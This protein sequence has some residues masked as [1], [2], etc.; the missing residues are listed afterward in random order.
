MIS[1]IVLAHNQVEMTRRCLEAVCRLRVS[2]S[3][4]LLCVDNGST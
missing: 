2:Q 3:W 1:I 4:E